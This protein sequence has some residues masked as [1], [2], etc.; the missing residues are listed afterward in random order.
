MKTSKTLAIFALHLLIAVCYTFIDVLA[1]NEEVKPDSVHSTVTSRTSIFQ[2]GYTFRWLNT[3]SLNTALEQAGYSDLAGGMWDV[4]VSTVNQLPNGMILQNNFGLGLP[5]V[6]RRIATDKIFTATLVQGTF[7]T[8]YGYNF[9]NSESFSVQGMAGLEVQMYYLSLLQRRADLDFVQSINNAESQI[10]RDFWIPRVNLPIMVSTEF[11]AFTIYFPSHNP[12]TTIPVP[13]F[14]QLALS[15]TIG[16][17]DGLLISSQ[18]NSP[19]LPAS[20]PLVRIAIGVNSAE[21]AQKLEASKK[22]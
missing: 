12:N 15:Y 11:K 21:Y 16:L 22:Q 2:A 4:F 5:L 9:V 13:Y 7:S 19:S 14:I 10:V 17:S 18:R 1:Q 8:C 6:S 20:G 3:Q